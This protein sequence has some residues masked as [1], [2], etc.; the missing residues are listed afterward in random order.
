MR[1]SYSAKASDGQVVQGEVSAPDLPTAIAELQAQGWEIVSIEAAEEASVQCE[2]EQTNRFDIQAAMAVCH[3]RGQP[4][5]ALLRRIA[6]EHPRRG[7]R[8]ELRRLVQW[9]D[10]PAERI[11]ALN[12]PR[13]GALLSL[14]RFSPDDAAAID[15]TCWLHQVGLLEQRRQS[16]WRTRI[17]VLVLCTVG[18]AVLVATSFVVATYYRDMYVEFGM[19][20]PPMAALHMGL[21]A[22]FR[23]HLPATVAML[24][25]AVAV[26]AVIRRLASKFFLAKRLFGPLAA[27]TSADLWAMGW[28]SR[29]LSGWIGLGLPLQ[30]ALQATA[31]VAGQRYLEE[32][33]RQWA[34][35]VAAEKEFTPR[36]ASRLRRLPPLIQRSLTG[37]LSREQR[38]AVL[39]H[40]GITY[41]DRASRRWKQFAVLLPILGTLLLGILVGM[42][43]I[44]LFAP[45]VTLVSELA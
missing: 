7:T 31:S 36:T 16:V 42:T 30:Q 18:L 9:L 39:D 10:T 43:V 35:L 38:M 3:Q 6:Q 17:F 2:E 20:T 34:Q 25:I 37:E 22:A 28:S 44:S 11:G 29:T 8:R 1:F 15:W 26:V 33:F 4:W 5:K 23:E 19:R 14:V 40:L 13:L 24:L 41:I 21:A 32:A 45:L 27:G 12:G